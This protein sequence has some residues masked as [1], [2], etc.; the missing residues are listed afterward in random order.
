M[1]KS[2]LAAVAATL[3]LFGAGAAKAET[4]GEIGRLSGQWSRL[5][6]WIDSNDD[7]GLSPQEGVYISREEHQLIYPTISVIRQSSADP[8]PQVREL[9]MRMARELERLDQID[10]D[11]DWTEDSQIIFRLARNLVEL[12]RICQMSSGGGGGGGACDQLGGLAQHW[13]KLGAY[14]DQHDDDGLDMNEAQW[15]S[16]EEHRLIVPTTQL[17]SQTIGDPRPPVRNMAMRLA[18]DLQRLDQIDDDNDWRE[19]SQIIWRLMRD[20][21]RFAGLCRM[22]M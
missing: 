4:C 3:L 5:G 18:A 8:R 15:I 13:M 21:E 2:T 22:G 6:S 16:R 20:L 10:D 11:N 14:I 17:V 9:S 12:A 7:D 19:D 1:F